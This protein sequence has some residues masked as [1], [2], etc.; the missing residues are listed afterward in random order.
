MDTRQTAHF[1][2][3]AGDE[4]DFGA[5]PQEAL[6]ALMT[7]LAGNAF[8]P[9]VI[10][11]YNQGDAFFT[12]TQQDRLQELKGRRETLTAAEQEEWEQ[13]VAASFDA[14]INRTQALPIVKS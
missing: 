6:N 13:L 7:R 14:T 5:T 10:L 1:R 9:I 8:T 3:I 2:V 4:Q 12:Q 11:P